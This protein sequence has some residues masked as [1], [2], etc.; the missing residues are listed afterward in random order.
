MMDE[1]MTPDHLTRFQIQGD[2]RVGI[3]IVARALTTQEIAGVDRNQ[4][5]THA[6][7]LS[8]Y[9]SDIIAALDFLLSGI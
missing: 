3:S 6:Y 8:S 2:Q 9:R 1:L 4:L 7:D 5:G